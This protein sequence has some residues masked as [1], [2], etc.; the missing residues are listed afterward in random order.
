MPLPENAP[1]PG[2]ESDMALS[3]YQLG[4]SACNS[5]Q[6]ALDRHAVNRPN[7]RFVWEFSVEKV[8]DQIRCLRAF[9]WPEDGRSFESDPHVHF[10]VP[11]MAEEPMRDVRSNLQRLAVLR[12]PDRWTGITR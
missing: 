11:S 5:P 8:V 9:H 1:F 2:F 10:I 3:L 7:A 4:H 6:E 12:L